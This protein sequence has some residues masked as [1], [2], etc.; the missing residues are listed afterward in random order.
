MITKRYIRSVSTLGPHTELDLEYRKHLKSNFSGS[1]A[2]RMTDLALLVGEITKDAQ[3]DR[4]D[5]VVYATTY[6]ESRCLEKYLE[7]FPNPSPLGFQNSIHPS[8]IE[9]VMIARKHPL[10]E[11]VPLAGREQILGSALNAAFCSDKPKQWLVFAEERSTWLTDI[12][13]ASEAFFAGLIELGLEAEDSIGSVAMD[14][15][16][17][18]NG[19]DPLLFDLFKVL[20]DRSASTF[21]TK[22]FG[23]FAF[24]WK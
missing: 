14:G 1:A 3:I 12:G 20:S 7:S 22:G 6:S 16:A 9:Q 5:T 17:T 21:T 24:E 8:G 18:K 15:A 11:L 19:E 4:S 23:T 2:R 13:Y 10:D